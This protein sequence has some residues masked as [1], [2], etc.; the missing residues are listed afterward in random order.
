MDGACGE[1]RALIG[2]ETWDM[3]R[4]ESNDWNLPSFSVVER[5]DA[6]FEVARER[7]CVTG[8]REAR[9]ST[10]VRLDQ[11]P[12]LP[13]LSADPGAEL[14]EV[15]DSRGRLRRYEDGAREASDSPDGR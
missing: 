8:G 13:C 3:L 11:V 15:P 9:L 7:L 1:R 12:L 6:T 4:R 14:T 2:M 5:V 10:L